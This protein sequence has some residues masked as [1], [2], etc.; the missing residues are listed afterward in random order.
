MATKD[1]NWSKE[2][3]VASV[4]AYFDIFRRVK[5]EEKFVMTKVMIDLTRTVLPRRWDN[6]VFGPAT[7]ISGGG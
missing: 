3:I 1:K 5:S 2:E 6:S 7:C 4:D